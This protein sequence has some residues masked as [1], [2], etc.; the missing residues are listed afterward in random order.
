MF[1]YI[2][3][4]LTSTWTEQN[5]SLDDCL[6][7]A[8]TCC[9]RGSDDTFGNQPYQQGLTSSLFLMLRILDLPQ[10]GLALQF[11]KWKLSLASSSCLWDCWHFLCS[12]PAIHKFSLRCHL[13]KLLV[14]KGYIDYRFTTSNA[15]VGVFY[16]PLR[17]SDYHIFLCLL[18]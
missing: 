16:L 18:W 11:H 2:Q 1:I 12:P 15:W 9:G 6:R 13:L 8:F 17:Q 14:C 3:I 5:R 7:S 10:P 4:W